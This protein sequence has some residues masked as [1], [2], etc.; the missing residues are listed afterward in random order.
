[1]MSFINDSVIASYKKEQFLLA[2]YLEQDLNM[3][4]EFI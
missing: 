3:K 2:V 4:I 1:M